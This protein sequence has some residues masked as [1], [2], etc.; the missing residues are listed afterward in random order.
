LA[1]GVGGCT[2]AAMPVQSAREWIRREWASAASSLL[3]FYLVARLHF[4]VDDAFISYRYGKHL[5]D[6]HGL[7]WNIGEQPP[8]EGFS[9]FLWTVMSACAELCGGAPDVWANAIGVACGFAI[10]LR[11]AQLIRARVSDD[12]WSGPLTALVAAGLSP[13]AAWSTGG[14]ETAA[15]S[16]AVFLVFERL[17]IERDRPHVVGASI[18]AA[19]AVLVRA[20]GFVWVGMALVAALVTSSANS[21]R[22]MMR[23]IAIVGAV[24]CATT[25]AYLAFRLSYFGELGPNTARI[26]VAFGAKYLLRGVQYVSSLLLCVL[27]IPLVIG[28]ALVRWR[29]DASGLARGSL[30]FLAGAFSYLIVIGGDWMM[31]YRM[32]V[33]TMPFVVVLAGC[34]IGTFRNAHLRAPVAIVCALLG[35]LPAFDLH[36]VPQRVRGLAHFRWSQEFRSEYAMWKKGVEDMDAWIEIGRALA[37]HTKPGE[38]MVIGNIGAFGYFPSNLVVYDTQGLTNREELQPLDP[39]AREMPGH[40]RKVVMSTFEKYK[41]TY[42]TARIVDS[43]DPWN[44]VPVPKQ[45]QKLDEQ[46]RIVDINEVGRALYDFEM[47]PLSQQDG[48]RENRALLLIRFKR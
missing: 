6:G 20:D 22:A 29:H 35:A 44:S 24:A 45:W 1:A 48:F 46:G 41:P 15:F 13:L 40:D 9:N 25:L 10:C 17:T 37:L 2:I 28:A 5:A 7:V 27:V 11:S 47:L 43:V 42:L 18:A 31:F 30:V 21:R 23:S 12:P 34:W 32:A 39:N 38:S 14:L 19:L 16:L 8:V 26:K 3:I 36:L 33:P 4:L